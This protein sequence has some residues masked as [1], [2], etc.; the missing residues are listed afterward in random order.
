MDLLIISSLIL[1]FLAGIVTIYGIRWLILNY[2]LERYLSKNGIE[3]MANIEKRVDM[4]SVNVTEVY[5]RFEFNGQVVRTVFSTLPRNIN[6]TEISVL[7]DPENPKRVVF[8]KKF[9]KIA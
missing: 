7:V 1:V 3:I 6:K 4:W 9:F 2:M 5:I 8:N